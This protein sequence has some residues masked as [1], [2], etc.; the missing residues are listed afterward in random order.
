MNPF[1]HNA[2]SPDDDTTKL[3]QESE[4]DEFLRAGGTVD[5]MQWSILDRSVKDALLTAYQKV[6]TEKDARL[7]LA[8]GQLL[9]LDPLEIMIEY[10]GRLGDQDLQLKLIDLQKKRQN[11]SRAVTK[12]VATPS[13]TDNLDG[14]K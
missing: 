12:T 10:A 4:A 13:P 14:W 11:G 5:I 1:F 7:V 6:E 2:I 9:A 8:I 3:Y